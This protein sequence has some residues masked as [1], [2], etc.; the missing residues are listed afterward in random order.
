MMRCYV[1]QL[2]KVI[3]LIS[4]RRFAHWHFKRQI[5]LWSS[6]TISTW[7]AALQWKDANHQ[8]KTTTVRCGWQKQGSV[9]TCFPVL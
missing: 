3:Q 9:S 8:T 4:F 2:E 1:A 5:F 6:A 7:R